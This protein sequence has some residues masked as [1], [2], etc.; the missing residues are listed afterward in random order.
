MNTKSNH[1][2]AA[3]MIR[4]EL[5][6]HGIKA[7]VKSDCYSGG[8][9]VRVRIQ[10]DVCPAT[11]KAV[12]DFAEQFQYG[13]F[14]GMTDSYEYSNRRRDLPQVRFVF[15]EVD[16]S[17]EIIQAAKTYAG[18]DRFWQAISGVWGEFWRQHK[19]RVRVA[20]EAA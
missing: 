15:V 7:T 19:P 4:A 6:K 11:R 8:N 10:Q 2:A 13:H 17:D 12:T 14:D 18:E 5:K 1:A 3:Q 16:Y 9:S 20:M